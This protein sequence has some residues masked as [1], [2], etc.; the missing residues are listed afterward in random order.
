MGF[1]FQDN[2]ILYTYTLYKE[3]TSHKI[4][5]ISNLILLDYGLTTILTQIFKILFTN[6]EGYISMHTTVIL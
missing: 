5:V 3:L 4:T 6:K 2:D 1:I